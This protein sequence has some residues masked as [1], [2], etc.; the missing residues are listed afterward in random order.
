RK[1]L[2]VEAERD[3][4]LVAAPQ[5]LGLVTVER[6]VQGPAALIARPRAA[7]LL[8]LGDE[9][10]VALRRPQ[11]HLQKPLLAE[12]ELADRGKQSRLDCSRPPPT[13]LLRHPVPA[14]AGD[15]RAL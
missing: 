14:A 1:P 7:A 10:G 3:L 6:D 8:Q 2:G 9:I 12:L 4:E 15:N 5:L 11:R 13:V